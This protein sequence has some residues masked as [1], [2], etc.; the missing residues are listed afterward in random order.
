MEYQST[1]E[2]RSSVS[3]RGSSRLRQRLNGPMLLGCLPAAF[4]NVLCSEVV[5]QHTYIEETGSLA[6]THTWIVREGGGT[7]ETRWLTPDK[8]YFNRSDES[9]NTLE[10]RVRQ[11]DREI[12]ARRT[13]NI[14]HLEQTRGV[15][16]VRED[17]QIDESPWFQPLSYALGRF[18]QSQ[19][20]S[21][22]FWT[23]RPDSIDAVKLKASRLEE[24]PVTTRAGRFIARKVSIALSGFLSRF[25]HAHYWF[26]NT[27]GLFL[28]Y[29][30]V[31]G[32]PGTPAT[33]IQLDS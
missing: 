4:S 5:R 15:D 28:R 13:G 29:E 27:D 14:I 21:V 7:V 2:A 19:L 23:I 1:R 32:L 31:N 8:A 3:G 9:G 17:L 30:G 24:E 12:T 18:S 11:G 20:K 25:W 6:S 26:R 16:T 33:T 22:V 10:W